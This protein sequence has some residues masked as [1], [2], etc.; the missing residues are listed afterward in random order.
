MARDHA[1]FE[2]VLRW[3]H[4]DDAFDI[5]LAY[6]DPSDPQD[7]RDYVDEPL[8]I[9][10]TALLDLI[11]DPDEYGETLGQYLLKLPKVRSF[12]DKALATADDRDIPLHLRLLIDPRAP[13]RYH[14]IRWEAIRDPL[15]GSRIA[16]RHNV[17]FSRY[18]STPDWR[19]V[20]LPPWHRLKALVVIAN[21]RDLAEKNRVGTNVRLEPVDVAAELDRARSAMAGMDVRELADPDEPG[22]ATVKRIIEALSEGVDLFYLVCH[23]GMY[24]DQSRLYLEDE[25]GNADIVDGSVLVERI[26]E[27][28]RPP[29]VA[30]LCSCQSAGPGDMAMASDDL[31]LTSLG[32]RL[33]GAGVAAVVAMQGNVTMKTAGMFFPTFFAQLRRHGVIDRAMAL[34]RG[35]VSNQD[36]DWWMPVLFTRLKLGRAWYEPEFGDEG[37]TTFRAVVSSIEAGVCTPV[38]G[39]GVAGE[40]ILPSR[41]ELAENW[42][43]Q[44][45]M[46]IAPQNRV[47][48]AK[49]AQYL[50]VR[51][52]PRQTQTE[53]GLYL[54]S[55]LRGRYGQQLPAEVRQSENVSEL[56]HAVGEQQRRNDPG[57]DP[58][59]ILAGLRLPIY[60]TTSWT[61][62]L[63]DAIRDD[64]REPIVRYFD[65]H[66]QRHVEDDM[67]EPTRESPLVYHLFGT[68][69]DPA[70][71]VVTEDHYFAWLT[72]WIKRVDKD[73][74]IPGCVARALTDSSLL[75]LGYRLDDWEF[76]VLFR[77]IKS[78]NGAG[79]LKDNLHVGVQVSP[80][81]SVIEP[82]AA[83]EYLGKYFGKDSL[84]IY[85]GTCERFL[86]DLESRRQR[87][88]HG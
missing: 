77:S 49:V 87:V 31:A 44:W 59:A 2:I 3:R 80:E 82:E 29:T 22:Q 37:D 47:D 72:A 41:E 61:C 84:S 88:R 6:D 21:P 78:F 10:T 35:D 81:S 67:P 76:R 9:E 4:A 12:Y 27:L 60:V 63:E 19:P 58:Y 15:D 51:T 45:L 30:V 66:R 70:S 13:L 11:T 26:A 5:G 73:P 33:S 74:S 53:V 46:P 8:T 64:G 40:R 32:P 55:E 85:W 62:L 52:A 24:G 57:N 48:L 17:L 34:A 1:E 39:S 20:P 36:R 23:G 16:T 28:R 68:L 54:A 86:T 75:F 79:R 38:L 65:W 71:L 18:L 25:N 69:T 50:S 42:V 43:D 56:I 83:Q 7:R 14:Q